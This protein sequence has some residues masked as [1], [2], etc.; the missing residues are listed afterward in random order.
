[1]VSSL[2]AAWSAPVP[3]PGP[4]AWSAPVVSSGHRQ[5][6]PTHGADDLPAEPPDEG[7]TGQHEGHDAQ[8]RLDRGEPG[9][10]STV[11]KGQQGDLVADRAPDGKPGQ[12]PTGHPEAAAAARDALGPPAVGVT[13]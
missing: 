1:M 7:D 6:G 3:A 5:P 9:D 12:H 13:R 11:T 8:H 10:R 4:V 2:L